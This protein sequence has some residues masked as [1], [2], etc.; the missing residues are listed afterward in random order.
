M[1]PIF[2]TALCTVLLLLAWSCEEEFIPPDVDSEP[3]IVV[4]GYVEASGD[5]S[6]PP[7]VIL[8]R[9]LPFFRD[10]DSSQFADFFVHDAEVTVDDGTSLVSLVE[11]CLNDLSP[12]QIALAQSFLGENV[13]VV[14][15]NFCVYLDPTLSMFGEEGRTYDL[16]I[17]AEGKELRATTT[18]PVHAPLDSVFFAEPP[19]TLDR[20]DL[21]QMQIVLNDPPG[22]N[23]YRY[24]VSVNRGGFR[25]DDFSVLDDPFFDNREVT[26]PLN[27]PL[28]DTANFDLA[29]FG[30]FTVGD[31]ATLKWVTFG[32]PSFNFWNTIEFAAA[33]QGPFSNYTIIETNVEGGL[34]IWSGQSASYYE[35]IVE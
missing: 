5:Q 17:R 22:P 20:P 9:T 2:A 14:N 4:E 8:T 6:A 32:E 13:N 23:F 29:T 26:I 7:Y 19:G 33:N 28:A 16:S 12:E 1:R 18:I 11:L 35:R 25:R 21:K 30:L 27:Q 34:G 31:T 15:A 10:L 3:Q 24:F